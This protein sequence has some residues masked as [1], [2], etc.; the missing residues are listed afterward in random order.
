MAVQSK[1]NFPEASYHRDYRQMLEKEHKNIDAVTVSTPDHT[2]AV[3]PP[4]QPWS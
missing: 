3:C 1:E 4:W 2:H